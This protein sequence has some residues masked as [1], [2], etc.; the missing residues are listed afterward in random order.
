MNRLC[1]TKSDWHRCRFSSCRAKSREVYMV[2]GVHVRLCD[3]HRDCRYE[4]LKPVDKR[5]C[6]ACPSP[7][8]P[9]FGLC[10]ACLDLVGGEMGEEAT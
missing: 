10:A 4:D 8:A 5:R 9:E 3:D 6:S 2:N 1:F 7:P